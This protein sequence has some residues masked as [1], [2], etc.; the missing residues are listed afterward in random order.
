MNLQKGERENG[1]KF[2]LIFWARKKI[3]E[4]LWS[5]NENENGWASV[6]AFR[7]IFTTIFINILSIFFL[8]IALLN[9]HGTFTP[10]FFIIFLPLFLIQPWVG[11]FS[12]QLLE[13]LSWKFLSLFHHYFPF[14]LIILR[15]KM[16]CNERALDEFQIGFLIDIDS[17]KRN[18]N[19]KRE[20]CEFKCL[21]LVLWIFH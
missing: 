18:D 19:E 15:W 9:H 14:W 12:L 6:S 16:K 13:I 5:R 7:S 3:P 11:G 20:T 17:F 8:I 2:L 21:Q 10:S 1:I 4:W